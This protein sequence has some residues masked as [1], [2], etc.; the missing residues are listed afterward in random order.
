MSTTHPEKIHVSRRGT[1]DR[2]VFLKT[3]AAGF[4]GALIGGIPGLIPGRAVADAPTSPVVIQKCARYDIDL[5]RNALK[6][7]FVFLGSEG[8]NM[9]KERKVVIKPNL[10]GMTGISFSRPNYVFHDTHWMVC[11]AAAQVFKSMGAVEVKLVESLNKVGSTLTAQEAFD[12]ASYPTAQMVSEAGCVFEN[13]RNRGTYPDYVEKSLGGAGYMFDFFRLNPA[14]HDPDT[15]YVTIPKM[16]IHATAGVTLGMKNL[17]GMPP[18]SWYGNRTDPLAA[19]YDKWNDK[20]RNNSIHI[21]SWYKDFGYSP[22]GE[23][24]ESLHGF[25]SVDTRLPHA[26][27]DLNICRPLH[28]TIIDG[29]L[30]HMTAISP[31][32]QTMVAAPGALIA[33]L[34]TVCTDSVATAVMGFDPAAAHYSEPFYDTQNHLTLAAE[35][36]LGTNKLSEIQVLGEKIQDVRFTFLPKVRQ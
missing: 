13:T 23:R 3:G 24:A 36:G 19:P 5:I 27:V 20:S 34:N 26:I 8:R 12:E 14:W 7:M 9:F 29:I 16:K 1:M 21:N 22:P 10:V 11:L 4:T 18:N 15:V 31:N 33:G 30:G 17:M 6:R 28:L 25:T 35:K 32:Q 2:R